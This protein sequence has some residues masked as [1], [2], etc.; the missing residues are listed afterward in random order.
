MD[1]NQCWELL[2]RVCVCVFLGVS[3]FSASLWCVDGVCTRHAVWQCDKRA[4]ELK[5]KSG[6]RGNVFFF[7]VGGVAG[8]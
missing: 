6:K 7:L 2:S 4:P 1:V 8:G 3:V 5:T